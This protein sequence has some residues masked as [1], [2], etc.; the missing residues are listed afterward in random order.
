MLVLL[1]LSTRFADKK[2]NEIVRRSWAQMMSN[3]NAAHI[4]Q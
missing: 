4:T 1:M 2:D 3:K